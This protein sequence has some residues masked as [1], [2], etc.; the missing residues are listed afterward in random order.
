MLYERWREIARENRDAMAL[1]E[2][3]TGRC[4][5]FQQLGG[6]VERRAPTIGH[7]FPQ[8]DNA[9]FVFQVLEAWRSRSIVCPLDAGQSATLAA[10]GLPVGIVHVKTTSATTGTPR[11]ILFTQEQLA[12]DARNIVQ[13]MGL[14]QDWPNLGTI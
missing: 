10:D 1:R 11:H 8:G 5:T 9:E 2:V 13:T 7:V 14:R 12:T 6:E 3:A 4:W